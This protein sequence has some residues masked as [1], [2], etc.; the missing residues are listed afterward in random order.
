MGTSSSGSAEGTVTR[1]GAAQLGSLNIPSS[2]RSTTW[3]RQVWDGRVEVYEA[4]SRWL[5]VV[6]KKTCVGQMAQK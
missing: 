1:A 6:S 3:E 4:G 5:K 2:S